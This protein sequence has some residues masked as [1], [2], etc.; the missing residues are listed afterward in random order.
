[1]SA[2]D[3]DPDKNTKGSGSQSDRLP[4][5]ALLY[6]HICRFVQ[7]K[8]ENTVVLITVVDIRGGKNPR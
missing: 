6:V 5:R 2:P 7:P 8:T 3:T 1:V 4:G